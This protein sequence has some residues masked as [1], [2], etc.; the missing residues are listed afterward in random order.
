M[1][2]GARASAQTRQG[3]AVLTASLTTSYSTTK[4]AVNQNRASSIQPALYLEY[5]RFVSDRWLVGGGVQ[6][7]WSQ[8]RGENDP[9]ATQ[10]R[11]TQV[12]L[13]PYVRRYF[14]VGNWQLFAG[15]GLGIGYSRHVVLRQSASPE[16]G[17][18]A[19]SLFPQLEGGVMY[20][21][22]E[23]L[24]L[25]LLVRQ[26]ALPAPVSSF[27]AGLVYWTG[28]GRQANLPADQAVLPQ[29][30]AGNWLLEGTFG[31]NRVSTEGELLTGMDNAGRL[32]TTTLTISPA[33]G[34]FVRKNSLIGLRL[35]VS[36]T[37]QTIGAGMATT[38]NAQLSVRINPYYQRYTGSGRLSG[39]G[40]IGLAYG[41]LRSL[42]TPDPV[43]HQFGG[44]LDLGVA[45]RLG[46]RFMFE[47]ALL[48]L[49]VNRETASGGLGYQNWQSQLSAGP[50]GQAITAR[51]IL[52]RPR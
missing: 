38:R 16:A 12:E 29:T 40:R 31:L 23:R 9:D 41:Q 51:Y 6:A 7:G 3:D 30:N 27:G 22:N 45:Y 47:L 4:N 35:P 48:S 52:N 24:A 25:Q 15:A 43:V 46:D 10:I 18:N 21:L 42:D 13:R 14:D 17:A 36:L 39:F 49:T 32:T 33:V 37:R 20:A 28:A 2:L 34:Y 8:V 50:A 19:L 1:L 11:Q 44:A 26:G 5:G